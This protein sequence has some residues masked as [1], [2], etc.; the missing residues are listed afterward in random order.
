MIHGVGGYSLWVDLS[1]GSIEKKP[2]DEDLIR[3]YLLGAGYLSRVLYDMI[4][5]G[6]DPLGEKNVLGIATGLL[7]ASMFPQASRHVVAAHSPLTGVW[8][9]SHAAGFWGAELKFAGYDA[10]FFTGISK[11]PVYLHIKDS[12]VALIDAS[13]LWGKDVFETDDIIKKKH[14]RQCRILSI[15]QAGENMVKFAA[16]MNDRD[17]ASARSGLGAVMGSKR[18]KAISV[19]GTGKI[20]VA[21]SKNYLKHMDE[22]Y[23]RMMANPFTPG[24]IRYGT[25]S[26]V[27]LM[28]HIGRLPSYNMKQGVFD[29]YEK[30]SGEAINEKYLVKARA[31]FSCL[32]RCGRYTAVRRGPYAFEGGAPEFETQSSMGSRCG[33]DNLESVLYGHHLCNQYGMDTISLGGTISWAMEAFN[34]GIL[35][36]EDTGGLDLTW[37][38][39][40]TIVRLTKMIAFREGFGDILAE[41]SARAAE[42]I[43]R[44]TEKFVMAVKRQEI[45]GQEPRAQKSMGL[46]AVTA[47]R[48]A[49]HLYAFP[50]LDEVGFDEDIKKRFGEKYLPEM[51]ERLNPKYKGIMVKQSEDFMVMIESVGLCKYGTQIPPEFFYDDIALALEIH[52]GLKFTVKE[53]QEIGERVVNLNRLYNARCGVT[54]KDDRLPDRL[55]KE[56]APLGPSAGEIVELDQ[57]LDEYYQERGWDLKTGLPTRETLARL[58]LNDDA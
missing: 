27:E 19:R 40:E 42:I 7:T 22:F 51:A 10:L 3:K 8:G 55:T 35:T 15:G 36:K 54:R 34:E 29:G 53:L 58:G 33:N 41:G 13:D 46:A 11:S 28:Q 20:D 30:I 57:M 9:E 38:N 16:I 26:L 12:D 2:L 25:T 14:G 49:D 1:K 17:R 50:V 23:R 52:N 43:G 45:A 21:D 31:D 56:K 5:E 4:P 18:L 24:R 39:H 44:G 32:Q 48:G 47:A 6:I 37:G